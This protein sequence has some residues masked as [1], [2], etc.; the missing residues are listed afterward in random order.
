M[1]T[2]AGASGVPR[3]YHPHECGW[4]RRGDLEDAR[5]REMH[6]GSADDPRRIEIWEQP[7]GKLLMHDRAAG[8]LR[9]ARQSDLTAYRRGPRD[10]GR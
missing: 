5:E 10:D 6:V 7:D 9:L 3:V 4:M 8:P 1:T 2:S